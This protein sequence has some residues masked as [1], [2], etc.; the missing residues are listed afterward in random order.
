MTLPPQRPIRWGVAPRSHSSATPP[1]AT[2][3]A[4]EKG[5]ALPETPKGDVRKS[6][7]VLIALGLGYSIAIYTTLSF[8]T[9][10][11]APE[12]LAV[13]IWG[14]VPMLIGAALWLYWRMTE[15]ERK[16]EGHST[17]PLT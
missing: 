6:A 2:R 17:P 10:G 11:D 1:P 9:D 4:L 15:K 16:L 5:Q 13:S 8:V 12:P 7:I 14:I 3:S